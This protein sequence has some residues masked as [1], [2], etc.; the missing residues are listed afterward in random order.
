MLCFFGR[1]FVT[2]RVAVGTTH[3]SFSTSA[4]T[5]FPKL[6]SHSGAKKRFKLLPNGSFKRA[7]AGHQHLNAC[8][9]PAR[10]NR[11]AQATYTYGPQTSKLKKMLPYG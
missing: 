2:A 1:S 5:Q 7:K 9:P 11:L 8:K 3:T 4:F 10:I 6:K